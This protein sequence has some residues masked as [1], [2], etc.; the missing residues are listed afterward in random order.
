MR[1][2]ATQQPEVAEPGALPVAV[3]REPDGR[4]VMVTASLRFVEAP[5]EPVLCPDSVYS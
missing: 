1:Q 2:H 5:R 4:W 3:H